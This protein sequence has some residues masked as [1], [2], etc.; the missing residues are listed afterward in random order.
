MDT[1]PAPRTLTSERR[2]L[3]ALFGLNGA[4]IAVTLAILAINPLAVE[5]NPLMSSLVQSSPVAAVALKLAVPG[6][7]LFLGWNRPRTSPVIRALPLVTGLYLTVV[8][9]NFLLLLTYGSLA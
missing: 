1:I 6:L 8:T 9:W 4:D 2:L 5:A 7:I 3:C